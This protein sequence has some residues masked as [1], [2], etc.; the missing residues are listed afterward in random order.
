MQR[1]AQHLIG[2]HDFTSF[3]SAECQASTPVRNVERL[4]VERRGP[5]LQISVSAN[6]FLHHM[7][8]N[9]VGSLVYV[10][11]GRRPADWARDVLNARDRAAAAPTFAAAGLYLTRVEYDQAFGLPAPDEQAGWTHAYTNQ[12][13]RTDARS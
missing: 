7:V 12:D 13:L 10:G 3:R 5:L 9:V 2:R 8:R 11:V 6:A 1:A 4:T